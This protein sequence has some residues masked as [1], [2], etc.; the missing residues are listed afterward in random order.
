MAIFVEI[1]ENE[2]IKD[3]HLLSKAIICSILRDIW[4]TV[5]ILGSTYAHPVGFSGI[6]FIEK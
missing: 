5:F 1:T 4:Q 2:Y 3:R 6:R